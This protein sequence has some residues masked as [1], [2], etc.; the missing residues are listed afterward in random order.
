VSGKAGKSYADKINQVCDYISTHLDDDL[1]VER[2]SL[3]AH[4]SKFHFHRQFT[5]YTG[6]TV[7]RYIL[8]MRLKRAAHQLVFN[9]DQRI[10]DIAFD[11]LF[12]NPESF[13]R[14]FKKAFGQTPSQFRQQ[15][16]WINVNKKLQLPT[17]ER[18]LVMKVE[19]VNFTETRVALLKH[20]ASPDLIND[21]VSAFTE[22]RK[23]SGL[24]PEKSSNSY[25]IAYDDPKTTEP[26]KFRF[27]LCGSVNKDVP[28]NPQGVTTST[29]PGG[30]CARIRH[31]G[32]HEGMS[33]AICALYQEWLPESNE[34]L[35][36]FPCFF[37][38]LNLFPAV[39]EHELLTDIYLP[40]K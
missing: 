20:R 23:E 9:Q 1:S 24:S 13:S 16:D 40:L 37:H 8:M 15:P 19:I 21:T 5:A 26:E 34:A 2:L 12:E 25:G 27:D 29:I 10:I 14:A 39:D 35:R 17:I 6:L 28:V 31:H 18:K 36:D 11:A 32:P 33:A 3:V 22:W 7:A 38:Y 4:F 30:R